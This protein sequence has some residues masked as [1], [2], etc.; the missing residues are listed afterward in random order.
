M[1]PKE[2]PTPAEKEFARLLKDLART[3]GAGSPHRDGFGKHSMFAGRKMFAFLDKA[4]RLVVKLPAKRVDE[5]VKDGT[6]VRWDPGNGMRMKEMLALDLSA[7]RQWLLL[8]KE[9]RT[10]MSGKS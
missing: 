6:G 9:A 8:A 2:P 1:P 3:P 10:Y 5:L 7:S 4:D